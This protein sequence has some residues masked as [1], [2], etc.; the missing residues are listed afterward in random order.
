ME[1]KKE[2]MCDEDATSRVVCDVEVVY[3][4]RLDSLCVSVAG[5][6][7][8]WLQVGTATNGKALGTFL[9][10]PGTCWAWCHCSTL[11]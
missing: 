6:A 8:L 9:L 2:A 3:Q 11:C 10:Q 5:P 4:E 1:T 7:V